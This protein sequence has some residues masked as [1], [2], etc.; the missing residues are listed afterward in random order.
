MRNIVAQLL[1][2]LFF[3]F[4]V[5]LI[6][7]LFKAEPFINFALMRNIVAQLLLRLFFHFGVILI[8]LL[9]KAESFM[10][11]LKYLLPKVTKCFSGVCLT[12][13]TV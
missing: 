3:H 13:Q 9:F 8:F 1:L 7:L 11:L 12:V 4:G 6:F 5:I 2:R 10:L